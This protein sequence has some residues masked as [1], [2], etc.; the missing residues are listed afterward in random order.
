MPAAF[1]NKSTSFYTLVSTILPYA[2]YCRLAPHHFCLP[3]QS[4]P[5]A[6]LS[7]IPLTYT[8]H[9]TRWW[10]KGCQ[11][12]GQ[13]S[14]VPPDQCANCAFSSEAACD[15]CANAARGTSDDALAAREA[16]NS[17]V[18]VEGEW[19]FGYLR[20]RETDVKRAPV[21]L[22]LELKMSSYLKLLRKGRCQTK[23]VMIGFGG[24]KTVSL[25]SRHN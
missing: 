5:K 21:A 7:N 24:E 25:Q 16:G 15:C 3:N 2:S 8:V 6:A 11:H 17:H 20:G 12:V 13:C 14:A 4:L 1:T 10:L 18:K 22:K 23:R 9:V 19:V